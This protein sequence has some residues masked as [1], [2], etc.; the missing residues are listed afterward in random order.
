MDYNGQSLA[1]RE[2]L[3]LSGVKVA[4]AKVKQIMRL[5]NWIALIKSHRIMTGLGVEKIRN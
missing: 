5:R 3:M 4:R 1:V 2:G